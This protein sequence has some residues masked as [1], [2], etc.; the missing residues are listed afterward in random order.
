M[1]YEKDVSID[2][3]DMEQQN[4]QHPATHFDY[5]RKHAEALRERRL[6]ELEEQEI[7]AEAMTRCRDS[8][9]VQKPAPTETSIRNIVDQDPDYKAVRR[10]AIDAGYE[11]NVLAAALAALDAKTKALGN[12]TTM[13]VTHWQSE[14]RAEGSRQKLTDPVGDEVREGLNKDSKKKLNPVG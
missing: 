7:L 11:V 6:A 3:R 14:P 4:S 2:P 1:S 8:M 13:Q 5:G 9:Y 12:I 10:R